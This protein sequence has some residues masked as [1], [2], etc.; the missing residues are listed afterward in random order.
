MIQ[1]PRLF[2]PLNV[3]ALTLKNRIITGPMSIV[4]LDAKGG[5]TQQAISFYESLAA[6]GAA[7]VTLGESIIPTDC[8][9]THA[10]QI[11]TLRQMGATRFMVACGP[12]VGLY[13]A[14]LHKPCMLLYPD[15]L[16]VWSDVLT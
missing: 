10:Q 13:A 8:G 2:S 7:V 6:G 9:K 11:M 16:A 12:G 3:G 1:Y 4:E 15:T 5:L 14:A